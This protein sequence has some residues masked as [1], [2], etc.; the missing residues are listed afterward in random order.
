MLRVPP[1]QGPE[2]RGFDP[3]S[4]GCRCDECPLGKHLRK[5]REW[6]PV[7]PEGPE[8]PKFIII[9]EQPGYIEIRERR[10]MVG[11]TGELLNS[12]LNRLDVYRDEVMLTNGLLC[13]PPSEHNGDLDKFIAKEVRPENERIRAQNRERRKEGKPQL[14]ILP[15][16]QEACRPHITALVRQY[17]NAPVITLGGLAY[18]SVTTKKRALDKVRGSFSSLWIG[19]EGQV[20]DASRSDV[21]QPINTVEIRLTPTVNPAYALKNNPAYKAVLE[22]DIDRAIRW[23]NNRLEWTEPV[24]QSIHPSPWDLHD[25]LKSAGPAISWDLETTMGSNLENQLR[26][27]GLYSITRQIGLVIPWVSINGRVGFAPGLTLTN[28]TPSDRVSGMPGLPP[29]W[30]NFETYHY[31]EAEGQNIRQQL[32]WLFANPLITKVGHHSNYY[33]WQVLERHLGVPPGGYQAMLDQILMTRVWQTELPRSL[34]TVG[35]MLTDVKDWKA[36]EDDRAIARNPRTYE[37]LA[38]YNIIDTQVVAKTAPELLKLTKINRQEQVVDLDHKV[39]AICREMR[40]VGLYIDEE[41][42]AQVEEETRDKISKYTKQIEDAVGAKMNPRSTRQ[43]GKLLFEDWRLNP[44]KWT[45]TGKPSTDEDAIRILLTTPKLLTEAQRKVLMAVWR[46]RGVQKDLSDILL[47]MRRR[48]QG[49]VVGEDGVLHCDYNSFI[50]ATGRISA[51]DPPTQNWRKKLRRIVR[52]RPGHL[53]IMS[54]Y[55]QI[56]LR[57]MCALA[58]VEAYLKVF[59]TPGGDPH[60]VTATLI[61]GDEFLRELEVKKTTGDETPLYTSLRRFAKVFVYAV[62][63]GGTAETVYN[64]VS[65]ATNDNGDLMFPKMTYAQVRA[66]VEEWQRNAP[67]IPAWWAKTLEAASMQG[68]IEEPILGRRRQFDVFDRNAILNHPI[69]GGAGIIMSQG[70]VRLREVF[71]PDAELGLGIVN[72]MHD[73]VTVEVPER[74]AERLRPIVEERLT[75][76]YEHIPGITFSTGAKICIDWAEFKWSSA[77]SFDKLIAKA[78]REATEL[79]MAEIVDLAPR[80]RYAADQQFSMDARKSMWKMGEISAQILEERKRRERAAKAT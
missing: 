21:P 73:A 69:Q 35:T 44:P 17:P 47:K 37:E 19:P 40:A 32:L 55:D 11:P 15:M 34:Y 49:G 22:R 53:F 43:L 54:D 4:L 51:S 27:I 58:Q 7:P 64:S 75:A 24:I 76:R 48:S 79:E 52:P 29:W 45:E 3:R 18:W 60:A 67:E 74:D 41:A 30:E 13:R 50:P 68:F 31:S 42:R 28:P 14:P 8:D 62:L 1:P 33:D 63:Y 10:P 80:L 57:L 65:K 72:Q 78:H 36:A 20:T 59:A 71:A 12:T 66:N 46:L 5:A 70:L 56:E 38:V 9:G 61:Y 26:T 25:F 2:R 6:A 39:H 16:P 77:D 23:K